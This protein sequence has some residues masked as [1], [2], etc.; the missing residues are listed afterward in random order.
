MLRACLHRDPEL[1][2]EQAC[3]D[4]EAALA[5]GYAAP[6]P[7]SGEAPPP[8]VGGERW[9]AAMEKVSALN[10]E[11]SSQL[12]SRIDTGEIEDDDLEAG[13]ALANQ[14]RQDAPTGGTSEEP[15]RQ[16]ML[17]AAIDK[18]SR[19]AY[20]CMTMEEINLLIACHSLLASRLE[21]TLRDQRLRR[22]LDSAIN[23]LRRR[24]EEAEN[25][26]KPRP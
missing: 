20:D 25:P 19:R 22:I 16:L 23:I 2:A 14:M 17:R 8:P 6:E 15:R 4:F 1:S 9:S 26:K 10:L 13:L 5:A 24:T 11:E 12:H 7:H 18:V 21:P 3:A